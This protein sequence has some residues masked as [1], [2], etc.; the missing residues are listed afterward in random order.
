M[1]LLN[2][3]FRLGHRTKKLVARGNEV[4]PFSL[5]WF[6]SW[7]NWRIFSLLWC[8]S[9][10]ADQISS[11]QKLSV[12]VVK[13]RKLSST[14]AKV[15]KK[16]GSSFNTSCEAVKTGKCVPRE[17]MRLVG[18]KMTWTATDPCTGCL[19]QLPTACGLQISADVL[20]CRDY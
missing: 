4:S 9:P 1:P 5:S 18:L 14:V 16:Y 10:A 2:P 15:V 11:V 17:F 20:G 13:H 3:D 6:G 8:W 19:H 12:G 7:R